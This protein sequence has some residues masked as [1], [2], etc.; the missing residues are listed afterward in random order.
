MAGDPARCRGAALGGRGGR[1]A[2]IDASGPVRERSGPRIALGH[3]GRQH[4]RP[5]R[6]GVSDPRQPFVGAR[7]WMRRL[8]WYPRAVMYLS[9]FGLNEKPFAITPDPRYLYL[10]E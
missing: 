6:I 1:S 7:L 5:I 10:S 2:N 4:P 9:F 8:S 3:A